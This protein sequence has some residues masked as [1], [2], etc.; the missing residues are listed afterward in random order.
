MSRIQDLFAEIEDLK[1][2]IF[3]AVIIHMFN[4]LDSHF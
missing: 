3:K 4:N 2:S 1:I